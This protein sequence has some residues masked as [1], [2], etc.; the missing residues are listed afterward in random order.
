MTLLHRWRD[1]A[2]KAGHAIKRI[3]VAYEAGRDGFWL[4]RWLN[5]RGIEA[6]VMHATSVPVNRDHRRAKTDQLDCRLLMRAFLGWLR[7]EVEH[8]HMVAIPTVEEED[9]RRPHRER[10][11][12]VRESTRSDQ[13]DE[14][15]SDAPGHPELQSKVEEG[16]WTAHVSAHP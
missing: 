4:A 13:S 15:S 14:V 1:E 9:T 10:D 16:C 3:C 5:D 2:K 8:C 12:L 7:G 6:S 11:V